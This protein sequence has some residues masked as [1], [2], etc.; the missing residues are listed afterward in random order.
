MDILCLC[1]GVLDTIVSR[2][3][4][5]LFLLSFVDLEVECST[6]YAIHTFLIVRAILVHSLLSALLEGMC[7]ATVYIRNGVAWR[8]SNQARSSGLELN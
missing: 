4:R 8:A 1:Y 6:I 7:Y 3:S 5:C 2:I